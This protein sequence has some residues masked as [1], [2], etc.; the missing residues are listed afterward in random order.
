[1][2]KILLTIL[3]PCSSDPLLGRC[4]ESIDENVETL[5]VLNKPSE[6]VKTLVNQYPKVKTVLLKKRGIAL[7]YNTGIAATRNE[8]ILLMDSDC[9]FKKGTIKKMWD[10]T[11]RFRI[12]KGRVVFDSNSFESKI[13]AKLREFT[14]SDSLNAY[15]PPLLFNK[16][17]KEKIGYYFDPRLVWSEDADFNNRVQKNNLEIGYEPT[18][19][20]FH[21]PLTFMD[22]LK[23]S[24][25]YGVGRQIGK[26]IGV[27]E[28]HT[29]KSFIKNVIKVFSN[30]LK[31]NHNKGFKTAAY[32]FLAWNPMFRLGTLVENYLHIYDY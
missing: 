27:Y 13:T 3:I 14:T 16:S 4:I 32:Y 5:V 18:A 1:M 30:T 24:F 15:S 12:V 23:S 20:I 7:A 21:R 26:E 29:F 9:I 17:I 25:R 2:N 6:E 8:W 19:T 10:L 28:P 11:K 31:I 22:D